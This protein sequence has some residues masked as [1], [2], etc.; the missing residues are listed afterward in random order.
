M[1]FKVTFCYWF[2][3]PK[4]WNS[5][6]YWRWKPIEGMASFFEH[7][8]SSFKRS[9]LKN[10]IVLAESD[11]SLGHEEKSLITKI[12]IRRG[13]KLWQIEEM[14]GD[15]SHHEI[16]LPESMANK[17]NMLYDLMELVYADR[18]ANINEIAYI[19]D[20]LEAFELKPETMDALTRLFQ[21]GTPSRLDWRDFVDEVCGISVEH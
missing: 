15:L 7:Q 5:F 18:Q 6:E 11:G 2:S 16:F 1:T 21:D 19:K 20:L 12:G 3:F 8:K 9:Y 4:S 14:F 10:L 17:M 13:L